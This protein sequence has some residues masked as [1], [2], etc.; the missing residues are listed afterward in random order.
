MNLFLEYFYRKHS[1]RKL[2]IKVGSGYY[3][4]TRDNIQVWVLNT[5]PCSLHL[6]SVLLIFVISSLNFMLSLIYRR[7]IAIIFVDMYSIIFV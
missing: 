7:K 4:G 1:L 6:G 5:Y 3:D 2:I